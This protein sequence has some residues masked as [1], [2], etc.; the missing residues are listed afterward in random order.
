ML[1]ALWKEFGKLKNNLNA[2]VFLSYELDLCGYWNAHSTEKEI[3]L[4]KKGMWFFWKAGVL[5]QFHSVSFQG[6]E[7]SFYAY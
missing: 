2:V 4:T 6:G 1:S 3:E 7:A 5:F